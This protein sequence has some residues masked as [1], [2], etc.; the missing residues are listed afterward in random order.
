MTQYAGDPRTSAGSASTVTQELSAGDFTYV[1]KKRGRIKFDDEHMDGE[2]NIVPYLDIMVNLIMF[3]LMVQATSIALSMINVNAPSYAPP[4]P[5]NQDPANQDP[6]K[7][8]RLTIGVS[9]TGFYIAGR[10][11][12]L[13]ESKVD[14]SGNKAPTIPRKSNNELNYDALTA[15]LVEIKKQ[16]KE[17]DTVFIAADDGI[18]Y[19]EIVRTL[20]ASRSFGG[21]NLFPNVAFTQLN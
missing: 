10:G 20:D 17:A 18:P 1:R 11:G 4:G 16:F 19:Q 5:T 13:G 9:A 8:P 6:N 21:E 2:I 7:D 3:L 14:A 15:L 12:V